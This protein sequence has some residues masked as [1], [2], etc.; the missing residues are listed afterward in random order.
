MTY[1]ILKSFSAKSGEKLVE[2]K[3]G[4]IIKLPEQS[5]QKL[6]DAGKII[7]TAVDIITKLFNGTVTSIKPPGVKAEDTSKKGFR[8]VYKPTEHDLE[9]ERYI[10]K[11]SLNPNGYRCIKCG[12]LGERYCLGEDRLG[13]TWWGWQCLKCRPYTEPERN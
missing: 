3:E 6:I 4:Q 8:G 10:G 12:A 9:L 5:A 2:F 7:P 1:K 11:P 13:N